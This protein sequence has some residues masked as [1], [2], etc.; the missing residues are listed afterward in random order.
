M[1][2]LTLFYMTFERKK[3]THIL[4]HLGASFVRLNNWAGFQNNLI[5]VSRPRCQLSPL[6]KFE[7]SLINNSA[8][9]IQ[10]KK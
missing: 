6:K 9:K 2:P 5:D 8:D 1:Y 10:S 4:S 3:N 7:K